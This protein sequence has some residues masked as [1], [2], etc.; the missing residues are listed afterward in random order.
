MGL[1]V[2]FIR[3]PKLIHLILHAKATGGF[4]AF[5]KRLAK[6]DLFILDDLGVSLMTEEVRRDL[7]EVIEDRYGV[8]STIVTSQ[9]TVSE[10]HEYF[11]LAAVSPMLSVIGSRATLIAST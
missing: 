7:L 11:S 2:L 9:L 5:L 4:P 1:R 3:Q 6:V 10:W 8:G